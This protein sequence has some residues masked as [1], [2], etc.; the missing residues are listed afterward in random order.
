MVNR[1][2][3]NWAMAS[4]SQSLTTYVTIYHRCH[5]VPTVRATNRNQPF[6]RSSNQRSYWTWTACRGPNSQA[7]ARSPGRFLHVG[8][9]KK[10]SCWC[11]YTLSFSHHPTIDIYWSSISQETLVRWSSTLPHPKKR[12]QKH[13]QH[14]PSHAPFSAPDLL[15]ESAWVKL[16]STRRAPI[17][18][19]THWCRRVCSWKGGRENHRNV[20][21][22]EEA[23]EKVAMDKPL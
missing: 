3:S 20:H 23:Y 7:M 13:V 10:N 2:F 11:V 9:E 15:W 22:R 12:T 1:S 21:T 6:S 5:R 18:L 16:A 4:S 14:I 8:S 19:V 17:A